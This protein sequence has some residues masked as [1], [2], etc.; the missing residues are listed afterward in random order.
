[1]RLALAF[2]SFAFC[3]PTFADGPFDLNAKEKRAQIDVR[4]LDKAMEAYKIKF[5]NYPNKLNDLRDAKFTEPGW[6][7]RD[8]WGKEYQYDVAG[9]RNGGKKPDLWCVTPDKREIGNWPEK[10]EK[11]D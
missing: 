4:N 9:K 7:L 6:E 1:M 8:P 5:G 3:V 11:K 2:V 10:K